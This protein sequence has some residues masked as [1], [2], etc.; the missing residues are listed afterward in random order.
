MTQLWQETPLIQSQYISRLLGCSA[1][2]KLENLQPSHSFKQ[3]GLSF[4][5]QRSKEKYGPS[6]HAIVASGGNAGLAAASASNRLGVRCTVYIPKGATERTIQ[7]IKGENAE[8]IVVGD[9]YSQAVKAAQDAVDAEEKAVMIP[10][11]EDS[12]V[13]EGHSSMISE[14]SQQLDRKPDAIFCSVGGGGLLAGIMTG[15][16]KSGWSDGTL[17]PIVALETEGCNCFHY[18]MVLNGQRSSPF[19]QNLPSYVEIIEGSEEHVRLAHFSAFSS[20][21][22]GSLGA[23]EPPERVVKMALERP[24][25]VKCVTVPDELSMQ[26]A[27][28]F[29]RDHKQLVELSCSTT[30][31]PAYNASLFDKL[32]PADESTRGDRVVVFIVCGGFKISIK[33]IVDYEAML[34]KSFASKG[35][36]GW[37]VVIGDGETTILERRRI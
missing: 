1:Y 36:E 9:S 30:L 35:A 29:S 32:V 4:F 15:C 14:I 24:G 37:K 23:S 3:R 10:A 11:Y 20:M 21:A 25:G 6:V 31:T 34:Q 19:S 28:D 2:L 8:V 7:L 13:W 26:A 16:E 22:S 33:D 12:V 5:V 27:I 17:V 18:S